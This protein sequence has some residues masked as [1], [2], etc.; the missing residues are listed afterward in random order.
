VGDGDPFR[1]DLAAAHLDPG[2]VLH[3][4]HV[5]GAP[6]LVL[7]KLALEDAHG[8]GGAV[9]RHR[10]AL[11]EVGQRAQVVLVAV[12]EQHRVDAVGEGL[13]VGEVG[14]DA[15]D[16]G[17]VLGGEE[18]PAVHQEEAPGGV[19]DQGVHAEFPEA[20]DGDEPQLILR[21]GVLPVDEGG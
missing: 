12:G 1:L 5:P 19:D 17:L 3:H 21:G 18:L 15:V 7:P 6:E 20:A 9:D 11:Q 13:Q 8:E 14:N 4:V 2:E 16:A 10:P